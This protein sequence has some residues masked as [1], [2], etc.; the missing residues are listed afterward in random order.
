MTEAGEDPRDDVLGRA[1]VRD[2]AEL[3]AYYD[4]LAQCETG[5]LWTVANDIEPWEPTPASVPVIWRHKILHQQVIRSL[6]LVRPE[7][8][9]RRV[10]YLRN[11]RRREVKAACGW[12]FS[13]IQVMNPGETA[14][15]H[16]HS[17]SAQRFIM[18]GRNAYTV[19]HGH[20]LTLGARDF[21]ITPNG[22]WHEH[23]VLADGEMSYWQ[24]ALDIPL[25]NALEANSYGVH[26]DTFQNSNLPWNASPAT[27]GTPGMLPAREKWGQWY[28]PLMKYPW[29]KTYEGLQNYAAVSDGDPYDGIILKYV[30]PMDG[31]DPMATMGNAMQMLRPA[32]HTR[33]HRHT[34]NVIYQVARGSGYSV[35]GGIR[36]DW[37]EKD[38]FCVPAW[39]WHEHCNT[40]ESDDACL[41]QVNDFPVMQKLRFYREQAFPENNGH[42]EILA[43]G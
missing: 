26:P 13:G 41:W 40:S 43:T 15:A 42:Q 36:F 18:G 25:T 35:I 21:V 30:N 28:S 7:D 6:E 14:S 22:T 11:P 1:R 20:R 24:D 4:D 16:I 5:A 2:S 23:G 31:G 37:E 10:V 8:A 12:I 34:G 39:T 38:I 19:V 27:Y 29:D 32:E 3:E 33:A 9:G 17:A